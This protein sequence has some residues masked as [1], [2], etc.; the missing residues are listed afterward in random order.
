M[1]ETA[2]I[3]PHC[4]SLKLKLRK[5]PRLSTSRSLN[6]LAI[7]ALVLT[8]SMENDRGSCLVCPSQG[9]VWTVPRTVMGTGGPSNILTHMLN[10]TAKPNNG[11]NLSQRKCGCLTGI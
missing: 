5:T 4:T 1:L 9:N 2:R 11:P 7:F 10:G 8:C 3:S 6:Y